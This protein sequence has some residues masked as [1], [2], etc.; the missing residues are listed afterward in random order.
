MLYNNFTCNHVMLCNHF[1]NFNKLNNNMYQLQMSGLSVGLLL[2][3]LILF[4]DKPVFE[5][6]YNLLASS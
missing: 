5:V 6:H 2:S 1:P 4:D 3:I